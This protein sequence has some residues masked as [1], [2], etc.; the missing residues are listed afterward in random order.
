MQRACKQPHQ[1]GLY[2]GAAWRMVHAWRMRA[3]SE[4]APV[5]HARIPS[6]SDGVVVHVHL[7]KAVHHVQLVSRPRVFVFVVLLGD[8]RLGLVGGMR[9][10]PP[11]GTSS[12]PWQC[13]RAERPSRTGNAKQS[14]TS[15]VCPTSRPRSCPVTSCG[16]ASL[17][18]CMILRMTWPSSATDFNMDIVE[19][20]NGMLELVI[21]EH[22]AW[23]WYPEIIKPRSACGCRS[24]ET[25]WRADCL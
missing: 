15:R 20:D 11:A 13:P 21:A 14:V 7:P 23:R 9:Q 8:A 12:T 5:P 25:V 10:Q 6:P 18:C 17:Q 2:W 4:D 3:P 1:V 19:C 22:R 16:S 24:V